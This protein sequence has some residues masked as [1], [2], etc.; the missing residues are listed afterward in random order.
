VTLAALA[1]A[2]AHVSLGVP[3]L[4]AVA[5]AAGAFWSALVAVTRSAVPALV[6]HIL[7][8]VAVMFAFP[9]ATF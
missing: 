1:F 2:A 9:Y 6:C 8:D 7:W 4:V 5:F 3:L